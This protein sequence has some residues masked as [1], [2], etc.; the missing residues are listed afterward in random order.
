MKTYRL[1]KDAFLYLFDEIKDTL[2]RSK[3]SSSV[4]AIIN[5]AASLRFY[6]ESGYQRG[7]GRDRE[8]SIAQ[9]TMSK[10]LEEVS[11]TIEEHCKWIKLAM[12]EEE[13]KNLNNIFIPKTDFLE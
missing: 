5:L 8:I 9:T 4:P 10:V 2:P 1:S 12:T 11:T 3:R 13:K 7:T 6:A